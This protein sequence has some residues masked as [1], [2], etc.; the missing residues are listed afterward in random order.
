MK[1]ITFF[2]IF[3]FSLTAFSAPNS[4]KE[5][6]QADRTPWGGYW[7]SMKNGETTLGWKSDTGR[8]K[9]SVKNIEKF[10]NCLWS[11][12]ASCKKF[13]KSALAKNG[14]K[15]SPLMKFD[16]YVKRIIE[17]DSDLM[18]YYKELQTHAAVR[19]LEIHYIGENVN[20][21][22]YEN[23]GFAGKCIGWSM[24]TFDYDEPVA[25]NVINGIVFEPADIKAILATFYTGAIFFISGRDFYGHEYLENPASNST[26]YYN[27]VL[28]H[29]FIKGLYKTIKK[30]KL[31]EA[32]LDPGHGVWNYPIYKY[33]LV[34]E[35]KSGQ[36]ISVKAK[37]WFA[38]DEVGIDEI[39]S[40]ET[41]R[42]DIKSKTY[43]FDLEMPKNWKGKNLSKAIDGVW[44]GESVDDHPDTLLLKLEKNWR[45]M[46]QTIG[47]NDN[48]FNAHLALSNEATGEMYFDELMNLYYDMM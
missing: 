32:D 33:D 38:N 4:G 22:L 23:A 46:I 29:K 44:T 34:W 26:A 27:D 13:M 45:D 16:L 35:K 18:D 42:T 15:L 6:A 36:W 47:I 40:I 48:A 28:P 37:I 14:Y 17:S 21:P 41:N 19:E 3:I 9:W 2:L 1:K 31:V 24:S 12:S 39:F 20:H 25:H 7:W 10:D 43:T 30:G 5:S 11:K 8:K